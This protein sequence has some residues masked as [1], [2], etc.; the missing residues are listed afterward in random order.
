MS[1]GRHQL[2]QCLGD[3]DR[4]LACGH[5]QIAPAEQEEDEHR[6]RVEIDLARR[7][8][9]R[10]DAG[11]EG[12]ADAERHRHVHA[13]AL[14]AEVA[15]GAAKERRGRIEHHRQ[16]E[17]ETRPAHQL[18]DL[19]RHLALAGQIHRHGV[20]HHLHH[21]ETGDE[22]APQRGAA[23][24]L[25]QGLATR[26]V[27][28]MGTVTDGGDRRQDARQLR[29]ARVPPHPGTPCGV[30]EVD[31]EDA[32][33]AGEMAFVEPDARG[34]GNA[35]DDQRR[36]A[37][38]RPRLAHEAFLEIGVVVEG[39]PLENRRQRLAPAGLRLGQGIAGAVVV[40]QAVGDD[41]LRHRLTADAAHVARLAANLHMQLDPGRNRQTTVITPLIAHRPSIKKTAGGPAERSA[42]P[43]G[44]RRETA[45]V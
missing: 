22:H 14:E 44:L 29:P 42:R 30:V 28:G 43:H 11:Q 19:G 15:P 40:A 4:A 10:P 8:Q 13:H 41:G 38:I 7:R 12:R 2:G 25:G 31:G 24:G 39:Q 5:L 34:T 27:V 16:R 23:F 37:L 45:P 36:L 33:L 32:R 9:R 18:L 35:F 6:H 26:G 20:H 17:D 3:A 1:E 21:P